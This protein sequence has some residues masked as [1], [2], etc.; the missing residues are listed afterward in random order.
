MEIQHTKDKNL[1]LI[2][3]HIMTETEQA[4]S[5]QINIQIDKRRTDYPKIINEMLEKQT[6]PAIKIIKEIEKNAKIETREGRGLP[7][8]QKT[9]LILLNVKS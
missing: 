4:L 8:Y 5:I 3:E 7:L 9:E 6:T 2:T 1:P